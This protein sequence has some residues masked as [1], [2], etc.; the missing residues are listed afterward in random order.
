[1]QR[2]RSFKHWLH[3][4]N[5]IHFAC[6]NSK[7]VAT[8]IADTKRQ[9]QMQQSSAGRTT[10][11]PVQAEEKNNAKNKYQQQQ[12]LNNFHCMINRCQLRHVCAAQSYSQRP[13][14]LYTPIQTKAGLVVHCE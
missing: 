8:T 12:E 1:M 11:L 3:L 5:F 6:A 7:T 13:N 2:Q 9:N 14:T 4:V 10:S